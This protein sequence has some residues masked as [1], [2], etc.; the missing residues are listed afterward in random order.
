[1]QRS[2]LLVSFSSLFRSESKLILYLTT[3]YKKICTYIV[4]IL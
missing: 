2:E 1:M 3:M 4:F